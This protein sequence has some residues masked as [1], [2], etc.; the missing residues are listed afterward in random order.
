M[1]NTGNYKLEIEGKARNKVPIFREGL[2]VLVQHK[3]LHR[4][5]VL[6]I[7]GAEKISAAGPEAY[8]QVQVVNDRAFPYQLAQRVVDNHLH[9]AAGACSDVYHAAGRY[10]E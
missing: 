6:H 2:G 8:R 7:G 5:L 3:L 9:R 10:G 4:M 1:C